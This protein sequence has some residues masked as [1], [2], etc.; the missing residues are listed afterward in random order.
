MVTQPAPN[1]HLRMSRVVAIIPARGGSKGLPGKNLCLV[2]GVPLVVRAV[3]AAR[4]ACVVDGVYVSTDNPEIGRVAQ[5]E[6]AAIIW[7][8]AEIS[9]DQASSE[10]ALLHALDEIERRQGVAPATLA[11]LQCTSPFVSAADVD[12][13]LAPILEGRADSAFAAAPFHHFVWRQNPEGVPVGVNHSGLRQRR[14]DR[15]P[16][17]LEAGSV[18]AMRVDIFRKEKN[19]FCGRQALHVVDASKLL[20]I[21]DAD[22]LKRAQALA[23]ILEEQVTGAVL[24]RRLSA[25]V[26]DF[27]G[28]FT[29]NG[30]LLDEEG[31]ETV[32]CDRSDGLGLTRLKQRGVP[33][34]VISKE[35]SPVV[36]Q[37]CKKLGLDCLHGVDDKLPLLKRWLAERGL[38]TEGVVYVGND[39]NDLECLRFAACAVGPADAHIDVYPDLDLVLSAPGGR[40]AVRKLSDLICRALDE[41][42]TELFGPSPHVPTG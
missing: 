6:G 20:E 39:I 41:R 37:R 10:S 25:V 18:Y 34:L 23:P 40:G 2:A 28:V 29:D 19:R 22:E 17:Y 1:A 27:D 9:G 42:R 5:A 8:P 38:A 30:V 16:E 12:G 21:D 15:V 4:G 26:F 24:P 3:R 36:L 35:R 11:F 14:Q 13:T 32:R 7:R 33:M 31:R